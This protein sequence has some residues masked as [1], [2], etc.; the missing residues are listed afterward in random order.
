MSPSESQRRNLGRPSKMLNLKTNVRKA[1][2]REQA[3]SICA[4]GWIELSMETRQILNGTPARKG[5]RSRE[6]EGGWT[7]VRRRKKR[8]ARRTAPQ[9]R[10]VSTAW[11]CC[12]QR[13]RTCGQRWHG[14]RPPGI[15]NAGT[16]F[17]GKTPHGNSRGATRRR[18][19]SVR[20][21]RA[22][23]HR[24]PNTR[25][26]ANAASATLPTRDSW[27][28][29]APVLLPQPSAVMPSTCRWRVL[30]PSRGWRS[31]SPTAWAVRDAEG[32]EQK[33]PR[34]GDVGR[35]WPNSGRPPDDVRRT[36]PRHGCEPGLEAQA[37]YHLARG[38]LG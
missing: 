27:H 12:R 23:R 18:R 16:A 34:R 11:A 14:G 13:Q 6:G 29:L 26:S 31:T 5:G 3:S 19:A 10:R 7:R 32:D 38:F 8:P 28:A 30:H 25:T 20:P 17:R 22:R 21:A 36:V 37:A 2:G 9:S 24:T 1:H 33:T 35:S 4:R 15:G